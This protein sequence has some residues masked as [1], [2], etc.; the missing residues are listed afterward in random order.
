[1][2]STPETV[3]V[4]V[5]QTLYH[6]LERLAEL[7]QRPVESLV[8]QT[9]ASSIPPLPEDLPDVMRAALIALETLGNDELWRVFNSRFSDDQAE[10]FRILRDKKQSGTIT[11]PEYDVLDDL[12]QQ[13]DR[14]M[15][16][17]AYAGVLLKWRGYHLPSLAELEAAE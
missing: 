12:A 7:T 4:H 1:M 14:L 2:T 11:E 15:L 9:L 13:A 6:R 10:Q 3:A 8:V 5:P 16:R 17:K